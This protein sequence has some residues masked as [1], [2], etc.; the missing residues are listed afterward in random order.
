MMEEYYVLNGAW[1]TPAQVMD[2]LKRESRHDVEYQDTV[3]WSSVPAASDSTIIP[4]KTVFDSTAHVKLKAGVD[5]DIH[6]T[7]KAGTTAG[8]AFWN[9]KGFNR[10]HTYKKR[11][12]EGVL[13]PR[14]RKFD[15]PRD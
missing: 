12:L 8:T 15:I 11:P 14:P 2:M 10:E 5:M 3:N 7:D 4:S 13:Y 6:F 9:A 1:P